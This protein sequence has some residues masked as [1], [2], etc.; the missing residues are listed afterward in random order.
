MSID[1]QEHTPSRYIAGIDLGTTNSSVS[2]VDTMISSNGRK[3]AAFTIE[4]FPILQIIS[5]GEFDARDLLP[6]FHYEAA[7][8]EFN[9]GSLN[10]PWD[11]DSANANVLNINGV[12]ARSHGSKVP[13][14]LV[15]SAK[16]WLSH[17]GVDRSAPILPWHGAADVEKISP[18]EASS[19]FLGHIRQAWNHVHPQ[20][21]LEEQDVVLTVPA[22]FDEVARELTV[23]AAKAAGLTNIVLLEEPLSAFYSWIYCNAIDWQSKLKPGQRILICDIGGGTTD[24]TL[25]EVRSSG[26]NTGIS[27]HRIAVGDH[28]I[29]GG[30]NLDLALA[31]KA[32]NRI[33]NGK[34]L[35]PRQFTALVRSC[36]FAKE[37]LL[38]ENPP[39][40]ATVS[41]PGS[42]SSLIGG[43][44]NDEITLDEA[45]KM[46]LDGFFPFTLIN[47]KPSARQSGFQEFGLPY[48]PDAAVTKYLAA[49]L[50]AHASSGSSNDNGV[51]AGISVLS[52]PQRG[53]RS[54]ATGF[55]P[56]RPDIVLFNGGVLSSHIVKKR[57]VEV[58]ESWFRN[59][60]NK[61]DGKDENENIGDDDWSPIILENERPELAVSRGAAYFGVVRRGA[62]VRVSAGLARS[63]YIEVEM[64]SSGGDQV[65]K[66]LCL[67]PAGLQEGESVIIADRTFELLIRQPVEFPLYISSVRTVDKP[68]D[69]VD[70]DPLE[71]RGLPPIRTVLRSGK[72]MEAGSVNVTLHAALNEIGVLDMWCG[73]RE[74]NRSWKLQFDV[75]SAT[76]TDVEAHGGGGEQGGFLDADTVAACK[77]LIINTFCADQ[78]KKRDET[79]VSSFM[80]KKDPH[81]L[82]KCIE[83]KSGIER[84]LWPPSFLRS[85]WETVL[86]CESARKIDPVYE[87]RWLNL[88][89]FTLRPGF[90][91]AVDDWRVKQTWQI[92]RLGVV[93][94][95]NQACRS[96]WW[97]LWRRIAG[98]LTSGQQRTLAQ[99]LVSLLKG[100]V[101]DN[102]D[103]K[104]KNRK[105][106]IK[107]SAERCGVHELSEIWRLTASLEHLPAS[108]KK[109]LG[110]TALVLVKQSNPLTDAAIWALGRF[111]SRV[112][113]YGS[114][115][116]IIEVETVE[117]WINILTTKVTPSQTLFLSLMQMSRLTKDRYRDIGENLRKDVCGFLRRHSAPI[118]YAD[119]VE[120]GGSLGEEEK[121]AV[122]GEQLPKGLLLNSAADLFQN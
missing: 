52:A 47:E 20:Y 54:V 112:P 89:G 64:A 101:K 62:G 72:G 58:L 90:G 4:D 43:S 36:Q 106:Q 81:S 103:E 79:G 88:L 33:T 83:E 32:E 92:Y 8:Q 91:V 48:A 35:T 73:E 22:S 82:V 53:A 55:N 121:S 34:R 12:F 70:I 114:L 63:Y 15:V 99:P 68:G 2:F 77:E 11:D 21:P 3:D 14:R 9:A 39:L 38:S 85:L 50:T 119:L 6:S 61:K 5:P 120:H 76:R 93:H 56:W 104:D 30:D 96:E 13:G 31:Y 80:V 10:L 41:A 67:V 116:E 107:S 109:D 16:S 46:L 71:M 45:Q 113:M 108:F 98:G 86:E 78:S 59:T 27:F 19:R 97:I 122:F 105:K 115:S 57:I 60:K 51:D 111:G 100:A 29:L 118:H 65:K 75:R 18:V 40:K 24:F 95:R 87:I 94:G 25:I 37:A 66:A 26:D 1:Q 28:L 69:I 74:G 84:L 49:F 44:V 42:G 102:K 23:S 110:E 117:E 7:P 17:S